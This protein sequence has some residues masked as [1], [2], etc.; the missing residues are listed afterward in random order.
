MT[1]LK[2]T[3]KKDWP[4]PTKPA[5]FSEENEL[6]RIVAIADADQRKREW[7][8]YLLARRSIR[9]ADSLLACTPGRRPDHQA[10]SDVYFA[11][12]AIRTQDGV[13]VNEACFRLAEQQ[14]STSRNEFRGRPERTLYKAY[15]RYRDLF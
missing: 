14:T 10:D 9:M 5:P 13:T 8:L 2:L 15:K 3:G 4:P 7:K 1:T 6:E 11:I 12:E